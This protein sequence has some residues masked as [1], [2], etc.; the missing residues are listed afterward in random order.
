MKK[1]EIIERIIDSFTAMGSES[2]EDTA[3]SNFID[4]EEAEMY[5]SEQRAMEKISEL[6]PSECFP[7]EATAEMYMEAWNCY[8]RKCRH[9]VQI[10][11]LTEW[12]IDGEQWNT[13]SWYCEHAQNAVATVVYTDWLTEDIEWPFE[14]NGTANMLALVVVGMNSRDTFNPEHTFCWYDAN[15]EQLFSSNTPF[16]DGIINAKEIATYAVEHPEDRECMLFGDMDN[17]DID[18]IF[19]E[20]YAK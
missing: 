13:Y 8:V 14:T 17:T 12:L 3:T 15:K 11:R 9:D 16:A 18:Y 7:E 19:G 2:P 4:R 10:E 6:E 5:L 20:D 1:A